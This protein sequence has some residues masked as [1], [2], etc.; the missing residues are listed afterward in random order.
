MAT[1]SIK[2]TESRSY[3]TSRSSK[4]EIQPVIPSPLPQAPLMSFDLHFD[5]LKDYLNSVTNIVNQQGQVIKTIMEELKIRVTTT[6]IIE[7][8]ASV[9]NV[10]PPELGRSAAA[11]TGDEWKDTITSAVQKIGLM[12]ERLVD[13]SHFKVQTQENIQNLNTQLKIKAEIVYVK[14]KNKALKK[15]LLDELKSRQELIMTHIKDEDDR[16][17]VRINELDKKF[18][19]L[20]LNTFWKLK[21]CED[22]L[23]VRVNEKYVADAIAGLEERLK[24]NLED[25]NRGSLSKLERHIKELEKELE[26]LAVDHA[27]KFKTFRDDFYENLNKKST[28]TDLLNL[29]KELEMLAKSIKSFHDSNYST[30]ISDLSAKLSKLEELLKALNSKIND[31]NIFDEVEG[32]K[33]AID[34]LRY[35]LD[36]KADKSLIA[37]MYSKSNEPKQDLVQEKHD[38]NEFWKFR[39]KT[40]E[41]IKNIE[42]RIEKLM[43]NAEIAGIK[44]ILNLKANEEEVKGELS[45]HDFKII[46]LDRLVNQHS[47]DLEGLVALVKKLNMSFSDFST[48]SGLALLGRKQAAPQICLSCG[49]GDTNFAP[50]QSH[51]M[52]RDGKIYKADALIGKSVKQFDLEAYD[53]GAE[54]F[55]MDSHEHA[56]FRRWED[57]EIKEIREVKEV[58]EVRKLPLNVVLGKERKSSSALPATK[59]IR[60]QSAKNHLL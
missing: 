19:D 10:V 57:S 53:T 12:G 32:L 8:F 3:S 2:I 20:E 17:T 40:M 26:K 18:A 38:F 46:E 44:K 49:R 24:K 25:M 55:A 51:V 35:E 52:G 54:V 42:N 33:T 41:Q 11:K 23:K 30:K 7:I 28:I 16:L 31:E 15:K 37:D 13:L 48:Q 1:P 60:P 43:K 56:H 45:S 6:D 14:K 21:D 22:L 50:V 27:N 39:E 5:T 34:L 29:Q 36:K 59:Y 9:A 58:K 47:K 4:I